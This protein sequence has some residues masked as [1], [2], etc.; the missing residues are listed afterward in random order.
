MLSVIGDLLDARGIRTSDQVDYANVYRSAEMFCLVVDLN[1]IVG[2]F[3]Y[4]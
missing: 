1:S 4:R 2:T 3:S